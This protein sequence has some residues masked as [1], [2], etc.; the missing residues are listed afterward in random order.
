MRRLW[1]GC[2]IAFTSFTIGCF[3]WHRG[4]FTIVSRAP[5]GGLIGG[6]PVAGQACFS[7]IKNYTVQGDDVFEAAVREA[8]SKAPGANAL[9][10]AILEDDGRC[11]VVTGTAVTR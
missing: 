5:V 2:I 10:N 4:D 11:V 6:T 7:M 8:I 9:E 1:I 3:S